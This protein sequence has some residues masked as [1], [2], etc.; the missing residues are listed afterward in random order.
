MKRQLVGECTLSK[1]AEE[2]LGAYAE[3]ASNNNDSLAGD[4][5]ARPTP[6]SPV[7]NHA[8]MAFMPSTACIGCILD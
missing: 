5:P 8:V 1:N 3:E 4:A 6:A 2:A 7:P